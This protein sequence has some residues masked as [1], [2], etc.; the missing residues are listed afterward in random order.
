SSDWV[1]GFVLRALSVSSCP[2]DVSARA[3]SSL[4]SRQRPNGGWSYN[5]IVPTDCDSTSWVLLAASAASPS[6]HIEAS[7]IRKGVQY[8]R[9]HQD[10]ISGGFATYCPWDRVHE[11]IGVS[12]ADSMTGWFSP[13]ICVTGVAVQSLLGIGTPISDE[14]IQKALKY[15]ETG[16]NARGLWDSYWW[17]GYAYG[18]C[19]A[20]KALS[21]SKALTDEISRKA[22]DAIL[23]DQRD[24]GSWNDWAG[25]D[26][27]V[28]GTAHAVSSLLLLQSNRALQSAERG[29]KWLVRHQ[30]DDGSFPTDPILKIPPP[31]VKDPAAVRIWR[32]EG[33]GTGVV[34]G[35]KRRIFTTSAALQ[36]LSMFKGAGVM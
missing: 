4:A 27:E 28:F 31:M 35:D 2:E 5:K 20:L 18:T 11:F 19:Q 7:V 17:K 36:A 25:D 14:G 21:L 32:S 33:M 23:S 30:K 15:I 3:M 29:I 8:L 9:K 26:G 10:G 22:E 12:S 16:R 13:H 24:D 1:S 6:L 34:I